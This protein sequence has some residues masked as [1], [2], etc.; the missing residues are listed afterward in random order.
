M[1]ATPITD[2]QETGAVSTFRER[3]KA[4][5]DK[6]TAEYILKLAAK[7]DRGFDVSLRY[8]D[9]WLRARCQKLVEQKLL[10][11]GRIVRG[12]IVYRLRNS[13]APLNP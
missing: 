2:L 6:F 3:Q 12:S 10:T 13:E 4:R 5:Q 7:D 9:D 11:R 8:R 1:W